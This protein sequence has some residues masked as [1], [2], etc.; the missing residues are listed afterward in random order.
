MQRQEGRE[1]LVEIK[2]MDLSPG[3]EMKPKKAVRSGHVGAC[4]PRE[5]LAILLQEYWKHNEGF[6]EV[7]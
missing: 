1:G 2:E 4:R 6:Y 5:L 3:S 7:E